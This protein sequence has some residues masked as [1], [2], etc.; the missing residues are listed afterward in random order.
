[1]MLMFEFTSFWCK[2]KFLMR[3]HDLPMNIQFYNS[4]MVCLIW[5]LFRGFYGVWVNCWIGPLIMFRAAK[6][7]ENWYMSMIPISF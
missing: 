7:A 3:A 4:V 2:N 6:N 1:M 5:A